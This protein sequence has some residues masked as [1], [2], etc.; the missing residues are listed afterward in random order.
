MLH[1]DTS[2]RDMAA[3]AEQSVLRLSRQFGQNPQLEQLLQN[4]RAGDL[5]T[6]RQLLQEALQQQQASEEVEHLDRARRALEYASRSIQRGGQSEPGTNRMRSQSET[7]GQMPMDMGEEGMFPEA[8]SE[9]DD[10]PMPGSEEGIGSSTAT[11]QQQNPSLRESEQPA[12]HVEVASGEGARRLSYMRYLPMQNAAQVPAEQA[13]VQYQ[14][15]A[16]AVLTQEHI[17]RA[18]REQIKQYFLSLGMVK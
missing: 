13:A 1:N 2:P 4:L 6:A 17:P 5:D 14:H 7:S 16:E 15:A 3:L 8:N 9:M 12:S 18:Y 11:R 10:Y